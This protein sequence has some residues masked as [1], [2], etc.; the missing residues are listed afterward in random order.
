MRK[1]IRV[2]GLSVLV[3]LFL[4]LSMLVIPAWS[5]SEDICKE[6]P[7][8]TGK[9]RWE[10]E[11]I[12]T[13]YSSCLEDAVGH[14][15]CS[16]CNSEKDDTVPG[17]AM[18]GHDWSNKDGIC[19]WDNC[20]YECPHDGEIGII[21]E[22]KPTC[23][24][25]GFAEGTY[26]K[27]CNK[28]LE[29][30]WKDR[31]WHD[32]DPDT[33]KCKRTGCDVVC[34]HEMWN[35]DEGTC[36]ECGKNCDHDWSDGNGQCKT[37]K[38]YCPHDWDSET[39]TCKDC[40]LK[41]YHNFRDE[42]GNCMNCG[43]ACDHDWTGKDGV[44]KTC[45]TNCSHNWNVQTG[46]CLTCGKAC[47]HE[48][49]NSETGACA[50]CGKAC[51]HDW[52]AQTGKC[53]ICGKSC[54]HDW[55]SKDGICKTCGEHC[56]HETVEN[57]TCTRCEK[58]ICDHSGNTN[59]NNC[60]KAVECSVCHTPGAIPAIGSHTP[61]T[62][63][64]VEATCAPGKTEG[65]HC[66]HCGEVLVKQETIPAR[67]EHV[68]SWAPGSSHIEIE[69]TCTT[70]GKY[71]DATCI[72]CGTP[73]T[74]LV[75]PATGHNWREEYYKYY[76]AN[77]IQRGKV[78]TTYKTTPT[79]TED[80]QYWGRYCTDCGIFEEGAIIPALG[81]L[82]TVATS[83][84][85]E[86]TCTTVGWTER[87]VCTDCGKIAAEPKVI[88]PLEHSPMGI[89]VVLK[90]ATCTEDGKYA[91]YL[92]GVCNQMVEGE[93]IPA[94]GHDFGSTG[95]QQTQRSLSFETLRIALKTEAS[96]IFGNTTSDKNCTNPA[97]STGS[98]QRCGF[99]AAKAGVGLGEH[100]HTNAVGK[101]EPTCTE[102]GV[103]T[104]YYCAQCEKVVVG[105]TIPATGHQ[106]KTIRQ[107]DSEIKYCTVCGEYE[108]YLAAEK[109][110]KLTL[111]LGAEKT[112]DPTLELGKV[113]TGVD[114]TLPSLEI[115]KGTL[116]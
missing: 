26:C 57:N 44:C 34:T 86:P 94:L 8:G 6:N 107:G 47:A 28:T 72:R 63:P 69:A 4:L 35:S 3:A 90:A 30:E 104:A 75:I 29:R 9:H 106:W 110:G 105:E 13:S 112:G 98:C 7:D 23:L 12:D 58:M 62:D 48:E 38:M 60:L 20:R 2:R 95:K 111:D 33:G 85:V 102:D 18:G 25:E 109:K 103:Y 73:M 82:H 50:T 49:W 54:T 21:P 53:E 46:E 32:W 97:K 99:L 93:T 66:G 39:G 10:L 101:K 42:N 52:N 96:S 100:D 45:H 76:M 65:S 11:Y 59:K 87:V 19:A 41:C 56:T 79:C 16:Y 88:P 27:I 71:R 78:N 61:V 1:L 24:E 17:T 80:G 43:K 108:M 77:E 40:K 22:V 15:I 55:S 115:M 5:A 116:G 83:E 51:A 113:K 89:R 81:H 37:C 68:A 91:D 36:Y 14:Y 31:L 67:E 64:A 114:L 92:C 70:D 84:R 74:D